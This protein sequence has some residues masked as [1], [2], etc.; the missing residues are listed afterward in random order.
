MK[1]PVAELHQPFQK[2]KDYLEKQDASRLLSDPYSHLQLLALQQAIAAHLR[3]LEI[4]PAQLIKQYEKTLS[5][6]G[7]IW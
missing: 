1:H 4:D 2:L 7:E 3:G 6:A 5:E